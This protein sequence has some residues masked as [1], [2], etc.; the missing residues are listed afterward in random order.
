MFISDI[1]Y[2]NKRKQAELGAYVI[3]VGAFSTK[4]NANRLKLQV[5][6][7]G[8]DVYINNVESK[9]KTLYAVRVNRYKTKNRAEKIGKDI[10]TKI[11]VDYRVLYRPL[12]K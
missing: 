2:F 12:V 6:Q 5:S 7:L 10:K 3:Q 8:Y 11:G 1:I 4:E 9:G